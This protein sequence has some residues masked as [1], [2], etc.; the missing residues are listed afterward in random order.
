M[1]E[2]DSR[3]LR[4]ALVDDQPLVRTG[5]AMVIDS[6]DDMEVVVQASDGAAAVDLYGNAALAGA[7]EETVMSVSLSLRMLLTIWQVEMETA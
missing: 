7:L 3:P 6:Q 1:T 4:V 2:T 5:F